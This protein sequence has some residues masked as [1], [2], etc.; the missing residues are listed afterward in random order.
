MRYK[1]VVVTGGAGF[2]GSAIAVFLKRAYPRARIIALDNLKRRG[3]EL[4]IARLKEHGV[5]FAHSDL[6]CPEDLRLNA[7]ADLIIECS[8]EPSVL[9]GFGDNPA[10]IINTNLSTTINCLELARKDRADII[11]LS[12]S[13]VYPYEKIN[14]VKFGVSGDRFV[15]KKQ[16][17]VNGWSARGLS[18]SFSLD[19][20]RTLYGATKL[21]SEL[22][23]LEY[24]KQ[25]G[26][27][28][29]I[30]RLGV[31][32]GPGQFGRTDQGVFALWVLAHY[33]KEPLDY[34]GFGGTGRQVRDLVHVDDVCELIDL[35]MRLMPKVTGSIYNAGGGAQHSLSL[36]EA[37]RA[38]RHITGNH[39]K[40]GRKP[41]ARPGDV[42]LYITDNGKV[43]RE[44]G[45]RPKKKPF[46]TLADI[47]TWIQANE[48][49]LGCYREKN[50]A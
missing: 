30:N 38:C 20:P 2:I 50:K 10:Y 32:A 24:L 21:A 48:S 1:N 41:Q 46:D 9:A 8:A 35:E 18:E 22:L 43:S 7:K 29:V 26:L 17:A 31:V 39:I 45:W 25:Y 13:R 47:H 28:G 36:A 11:F 16:R 4:N 40:I 44:L 37:T 27:R 34:I 5:I 14:A 19:G 3:S 33:F 49:Q 12:T 6:R 23:M 15:W 42:A